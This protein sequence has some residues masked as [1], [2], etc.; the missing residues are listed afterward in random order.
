VWIG[1]ARKRN[2]YSGH[3]DYNL[4]IFLTIFKKPAIH[5]GNF[6]SLAVNR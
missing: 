2:W 5:T 6:E 3:K 4:R 1:K